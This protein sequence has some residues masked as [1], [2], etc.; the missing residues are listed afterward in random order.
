M[1]PMN[2]FEAIVTDIYRNE[3]VSIVDFDAN[4]TAL[5]MTA[6]ALE[7]IEEGSRV[8]VGAKA[9][10]IALAKGDTQGLSI[11]N[12]FEADIEAIKTGVLLCSVRL[13]LGDAPFESLITADSAKRLGLA[14]GE[15]VTVLIK[16]TELFIAER[17]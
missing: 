9:S 15:R 17:R 16:S 14:V 12:R 3:G 2:R 6:L 11:S 13:R 5:R 8:V 7:G 1:E 10:Q 4:G